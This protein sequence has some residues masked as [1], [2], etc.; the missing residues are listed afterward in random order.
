MFGKNVW[1]E[2][3]QFFFHKYTRYRN[4]DSHKFEAGIYFN[5]QF[6]V[7]YKW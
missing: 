7:L 4:K 2:K 6:L 5:D 3:L 1:Y